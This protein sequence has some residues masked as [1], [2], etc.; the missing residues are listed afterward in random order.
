MTQVLCNEFVSCFLT[1]FLL[2]IH[3]KFFSFTSYWQNY[4]KAYNSLIIGVSLFFHTE[5]KVL[6]RP[7][8][9]EIHLITKYYLVM[10]MIEFD[11]I[12]KI[13]NQNNV[14]W[15][16]VFFSHGLLFLTCST[17][18]L[19]LLRKISSMFQSGKTPVLHL[20][21]NLSELMYCTNAV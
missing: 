2:I 16:G 5:W 7:T 20:P 6:E 17:N 12:T 15:Q 4:L 8:R 11:F 10:K 14:F 9:F 13:I 3:K 18:S 21:I 19:I 1:T